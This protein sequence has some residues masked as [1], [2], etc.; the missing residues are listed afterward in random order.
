MALMNCELMGIRGHQ[1][2]VF[3]LL[4]YVYIYGVIISEGAVTRNRVFDDMLKFYISFGFSLLQV[5]IFISALYLI[6]W[7]W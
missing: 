4:I 3:Q 6:F 1:I 5:V 7:R 2:I